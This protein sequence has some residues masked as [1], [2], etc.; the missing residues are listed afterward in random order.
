MKIQQVCNDTPRNNVIS[1]IAVNSPKTYFQ[2][3]NNNGHATT[4][5]QAD[6]VTKSVYGGG[7]K[8]TFLMKNES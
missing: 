4:K 2:N 5:N 6:N 8:T 1:P 3:K 7:V